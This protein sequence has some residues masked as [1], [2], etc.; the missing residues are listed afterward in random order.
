MTFN[1]H[2]LQGHILNE[3][4]VFIICEIK[5]TLILSD[6]SDHRVLKLVYII[7]IFKA[8]FLRDTLQIQIGCDVKNF[9]I[10]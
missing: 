6:D 3:T 8:S 10:Y 5:V 1:S 2:S 7:S 9:V 4:S